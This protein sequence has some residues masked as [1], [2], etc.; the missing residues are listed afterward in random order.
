[1]PDYFI[2]LTYLPNVGNRPTF[3]ER[4]L[5]VPSADII[6]RAS[7]KRLSRGK[8][9]FYFSFEADRVSDTREDPAVDYTNFL[10]RWDLLH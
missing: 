5:I 4:Y 7:R 1:M 2:F 6:S 8:Y 10:E 9:F 3:A